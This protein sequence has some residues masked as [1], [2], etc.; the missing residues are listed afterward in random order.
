MVGVEHSER[1]V[2][3]SRW[4][5]QMVVGLLGILF[6]QVKNSGDGTQAMK[7]KLILY[8]ALVLSGINNS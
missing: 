1:R 2:G 6:A 7:P 4:G 3:L 5:R 8:L